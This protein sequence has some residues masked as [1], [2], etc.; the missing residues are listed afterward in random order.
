[1]RLDEAARRCDYSVSS[2]RRAIH[3]GDLFAV[4]LGPTERHPIRVPEAALEEWIYG[5]HMS[6]GER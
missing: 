2:L 1:M 4:R 3:R 5:G 6:A